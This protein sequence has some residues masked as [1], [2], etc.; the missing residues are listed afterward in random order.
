MLLRPLLVRAAT[1]LAAAALLASP[2]RAAD[3]VFPLASHIGLVVP[4]T[5]KPAPNFRGFVDP[6]SGTSILILEV[7]PQLYP[8]VEG[9][10]SAEGLKKQGMIELTTFMLA[11][12]AVKYPQAFVVAQ[13][14]K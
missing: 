7:P 8:K 2:A 3:P 13:C 4:G 10:M 12:V 1:A 9:E 5:M 6:D 14:Q 11:D